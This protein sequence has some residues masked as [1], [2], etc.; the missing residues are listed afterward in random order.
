MQ[1]SNMIPGR[2]V[3]RP[4]R[5]LAQVKTAD[6]VQTCHVK[7]T[8]RCAELLLPGA[9]VYLEYSRNPARKTPCDLIAVEKE[10]PGLPPLLL[11]LLRRRRRPRS[12]GWI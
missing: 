12:G 1:Y 8:G 10:R 3:S 6:G 11:R 5:F 2:F 4:N 7:N 9:R